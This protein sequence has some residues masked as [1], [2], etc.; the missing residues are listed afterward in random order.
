MRQGCPG[1]GYEPPLTSSWH[2]RQPVPNGSANRCGEI[3][4]RQV[5]VPQAKSPT[6]PGHLPCVDSR[7]PC[8][9]GGLF[10]CCNIPALLW[11]LHAIWS[12]PLTPLPAPGQAMSPSWV[13]SPCPSCCHLWS[14][15]SP[16]GRGRAS[17]IQ[18]QARGSNNKGVND[19][20]TFNCQWLECP[21][22][23][24]RSRG[25]SGSVRG[26]KPKLKVIQAWGFLLLSV[27]TAP[28]LLC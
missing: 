21:P 12:L 19:Q 23:W 27:S 11:A 7:V 18:H 14:E 3:Q 13:D 4:A 2:L 15:A 24:C 16:G 26:R 9:F 6:V 1:A 8:S 22:V 5:E 17:D 25:P 10:Y 28:M 20:M